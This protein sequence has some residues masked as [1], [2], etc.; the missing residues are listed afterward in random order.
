MV[1]RFAFPNV[2]VRIAGGREIHLRT[3]RRY[4]APS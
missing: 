3:L 4:H 2:E 1:F